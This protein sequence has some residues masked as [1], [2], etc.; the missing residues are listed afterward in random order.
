[1]LFPN[2]MPTCTADDSSRGTSIG[3]EAASGQLLGIHEKRK[4]PKSLARDLAQSHKG[5]FRPLARFPPANASFV[6]LRPC[7]PRATL[8]NVVIVEACCSPEVKTRRAGPSRRHDSSSPSA[9]KRFYP[10]TI[11]FSTAADHPAPDAN[12]PGT[13]I[14][15]L[16]R[17]TC[18]ATHISGPEALGD[19]PFEVHPAR[20]T[21][22]GGAVTVIA[23]L[24][25]T[26]RAVPCCSATSISPG[27]VVVSR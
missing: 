17:C 15:C 14:L 12:R 20:M 9:G 23:S 21:E 5:S 11:V 22:D 18:A 2:Q 16:Q 8:P 26:H 27:C 4:E 10:L 3:R 1:M 19:D 24:S 25:W 13:W 7:V 6:R